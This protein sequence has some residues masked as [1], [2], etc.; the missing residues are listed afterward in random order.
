[1]GG[2]IQYAIKG[3]GIMG[4]Y[5]LGAYLENAKSGSDTELVRL[6]ERLMKYAESANAYRNSVIAGEGV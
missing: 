6:T 2:E 4:A 5:N 3:E 1:M